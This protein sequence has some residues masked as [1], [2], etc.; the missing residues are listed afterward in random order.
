[1]PECIVCGENS[2]PEDNACPFCFFSGR[3]FEQVLSSDERSQV[4]PRIR[5]LEQVKQAEVWHHGESMFNLTV[6]L[7]DGRFIVPGVLLE[8]PGGQ[9]AVV[10]A[11]PPVG[12]LWGVAVFSDPGNPPVQTSVLPDEVD[13]DKLVSTIEQISTL[14]QLL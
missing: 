5:E 13:D 1:M 3:Y 9:R 10:P 6:A 8:L 7:R 12:D 4:L 11:I 2:A 14:E